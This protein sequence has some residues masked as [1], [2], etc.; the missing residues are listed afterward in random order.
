MAS[1]LPL[2]ENH[3]RFSTARRS[4]SH[5]TKRGFSRFSAASGESEVSVTYAYIYIYTPGTRLTL[6]EFLMGKTGGL[7]SKIEVI[8]VFQVSHPILQEV[9]NG[10]LLVLGPFPKPRTKRPVRRMLV[11]G[12]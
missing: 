10:D 1:A 7:W 4:L 5:G 2:P 12:G 6:F 11:Y 3:V 8:Q 9:T